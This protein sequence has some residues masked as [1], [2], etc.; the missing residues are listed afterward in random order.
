M[1]KSVYGFLVLCAVVIA[2]PLWAQAN[3]NVA[4]LEEIIVTANRR[5]ENLQEVA[6]S[7]AALQWD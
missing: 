4:A 5:E 3:R 2:A 6:I 1:K 7:I